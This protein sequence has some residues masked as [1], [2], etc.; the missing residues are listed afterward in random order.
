MITHC[1]ELHSPLGALIR[2]GRDDSGIAMTT[3]VEIAAILFMLVTALLVLTAHLT[4]VTQRQIATTKALHMADAGLN[5]YLYELRRNPTYYET[6]PVLGPVTLDDGTWIVTATPD[7]GPGSP[8]Q[9]EA[10]GVIESLDVTHTIYAEVR[11]PSYADYSVLVDGPLDIGDDARFEGSVRCNGDVT[12]AGTITGDCISTRDVYDNARGIDPEDGLPK[13][14]RGEIIEDADRVDF[15]QVTVDLNDMR[16]VAQASG[17]Y[18]AASGTYG[19]QVVMS[20]TSCQ[21]SKVTGGVTTGNLTTTMVGTVNVPP[22]GVLYFDD[23]VWVR[24]T[25]G[26]KVT[27]V[28]GATGKNIYIHGDIV[29]TEAGRPFTCGLIAYNDVRVMSWYPV[30][31]WFPT[32]VTIQAAMLGQDGGVGADFK[33]GYIRNSVT[34]IGSRAFSEQIGF[35]SG[36]NTGFRYRTYTYDPRLEIEPPPYY[37]RLRDGSLKVRTWYEGV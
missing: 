15:S 13:G 2:R 16:T 23:H 25:Y 20:G 30:T 5:A 36:T 11:F 3:V 1:P 32:N 28:A 9:L 7:S 8:V 21:I 14:V 34:I 17:T 31:A 4:T 24:G 29:P 33:T 35:I 18:Y 26:T 19:Y 12:N 6:M 10:V 22:S 37:P 27:I